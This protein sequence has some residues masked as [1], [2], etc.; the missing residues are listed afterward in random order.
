M[1]DNTV[2][3]DSP[4]YGFQLIDAVEICAGAQFFKSKC[5][6]NK[7]NPIY[8][9]G[10]ESMDMHENL[11]IQVDKPACSDIKPDGSYS[12]ITVIPRLGLGFK[13]ILP[14]KNFD[15]LWEKANQIFL[16]GLKA[17]LN[18]EISEKQLP[19]FWVKLVAPGT[20]HFFVKK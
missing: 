5:S 14:V 7:E 2:H 4:V 18:K 1:S 12:V 20:V 15:K 16:Q 8:H 6:R 3:L 19:F 17:I 13:K 9:I 10:R 11:E